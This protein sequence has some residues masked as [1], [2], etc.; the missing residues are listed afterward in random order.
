MPA[1]HDRGPEAPRQPSGCDLVEEADA[2]RS[3]GLDRRAGSVRG[4]QP[5]AMGL[6]DRL[7]FRPY[8]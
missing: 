1:S 8:L 2:L 5:M 4:E 7:G 6:P 3:F